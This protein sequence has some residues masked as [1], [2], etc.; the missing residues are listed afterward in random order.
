[1]KLFRIVRHGRDGS[2][3]YIKDGKGE[4]LKLPEEKADQYIDWLYNINGEGG[5]QFFTEEDDECDDIPV[6]TLVHGCATI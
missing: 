3:G 5:S 2:T 1:M 4:D 6:T